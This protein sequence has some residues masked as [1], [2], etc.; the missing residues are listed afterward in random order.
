LPPLGVLPP[1]A[2]FPPLGVF[3]PLAPRLA[4]GCRPCSSFARAAVHVAGMFPSVHAMPAL[5][6][7]R[8]FRCFHPFAIS[9][10][11][12][13]LFCASGWATNVATRIFATASAKAPSTEAGLSLAVPAVLLVTLGQPSTSPVINSVGSAMK[14]SAPQAETVALPDPPLPSSRSK[15][16]MGKLPTLMLSPVS[17]SLT[18]TEK[19]NLLPVFIFRR[20]SPPLTP[21]ICALP[22]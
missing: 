1:L 12:L 10:V 13:Y 16:V 6:A 9:I 15:K 8:R 17:A 20:P 7:K 21:F 14:R 11:N 4:R 19:L 18:E 5:M 3:P 2:V 22:E